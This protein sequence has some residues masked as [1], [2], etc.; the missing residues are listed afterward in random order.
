MKRWLLIG[1][2]GPGVCAFALIPVL[3]LALVGNLASP[4]V[5]GGAQ[6][7]RVIGFLVAQLGKP[8]STTAPDGPDTWDCS[9]LVTGAYATIGVTLPSLTFDQVKLGDPVPIDPTQVQPGDAVFMRGG[10]PVTDLGHV[11]VAITP[12]AMIS[13]P[14]TGDVVHISAIPWNGVQA[15]RRYIN[16]APAPL[17]ADQT[18]DEFLAA[19]YETSGKLDPNATLSGV[20]VAILFYD[21]GCRGVPLVQFVAITGRESGDNPTAYNFHAETTGDISLGLVEENVKDKLWGRLAQA[22]LS[23]P[24]Q[25]FNP[26]NAAR[27]AY[28]LSHGCT[29]LDAWGAYKGLPNTYGTDTAAAI[30]AVQAAKTYNLIG[31]DA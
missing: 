8:Y 29:N 28:L 17:V 11:G 18:W 1:L 20:Q 26:V 22:G 27:A 30:A 7:D 19:H 14:K 25:L 10:D 12:T 31:A 4:A 2:I 13:A 23:D 6:I 21:V 16:L 9:G 5:T 24:R 15:V 3:L